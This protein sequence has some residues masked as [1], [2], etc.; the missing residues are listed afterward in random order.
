MITQRLRTNDNE[1]MIM[2]YD[3]MITQR[4]RKVLME[5]CINHTHS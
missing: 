1:I 3:A 4:L 5:I 2:K